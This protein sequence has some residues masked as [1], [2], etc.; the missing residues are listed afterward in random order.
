ME[1]FKLRPALLKDDG[2]PL[3][4]KLLD[5]EYAV[6]QEMALETLRSCIHHGND[7]MIIANGIIIHLA[8]PSRQVVAGGEGLSKLVSLLGEES[9][10]D[11][12]VLA[13]EVLGLCLGDTD[14]MSILQGSGCLQQLLAHI[15]DSSSQ[16]MKK[17]AIITLASAATDSELV[18]HALVMVIT[19]HTCT[20]LNRKIL[21][22]SQVES[23][24]IQLLSK[25]VCGPL[26]IGL[27]LRH[28]HAHRMVEWWRPYVPCS[29]TW[30]SSTP[31]DSS[32]V[33]RGE[34]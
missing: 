9:Y 34:W 6:I 32:L 22:E 26:L 7:I 4:I 24:F 10:A 11:I 25:E 5:S 14:S 18:E 33:E 28:A 20:A 21:H 27:L 29:L 3:I 16:L 15:T 19:P 1:N 13:V 31:V 12:H 2:L 23:T 17:A 30:L 8:A